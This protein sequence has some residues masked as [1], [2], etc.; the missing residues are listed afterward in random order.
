VPSIERFGIDYD[1]RLDRPPIGGAIT[2]AAFRFDPGQRR[3]EGG[4]WTDT[5]G[6]TPPPPRA[7]SRRSRTAVRATP[8]DSVELPPQ[9][10]LKAAPRGSIFAEGWMD[11]DDPA[12]RAAGF[13]QG[14]FRDQRA[15]RSVF[16]NI[17]EGKADPLDGIDLDRGW[18]LT[19][20][21]VEPPGTEEGSDA[22]VYDKGDLR[23]ELISA[24]RWLHRSLADAPVTTQP[25][26]R[27]MRMRRSEVPKVGESFD[28]DVV[29][30]AEER[31]WGEH[32]AEL[33]EDES[34]GRAGDTEVVFRLNGPKRSVDLGEGYLDEHLTQGRYRVTRVTGTGR[35]RFVTLE[36]VV[37]DE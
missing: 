25:L 24:A 11:S 36:E 22:R 10:P 17:T 21:R 37:G 18:N 23:N 28:A 16:R 9:P 30:W 31:Y 13:W 29:S 12:E 2:A 27:G 7:R 1:I 3:D 6:G 19:Y 20:L 4:R 8:S 5:G 26:Y 15:I 35:R 34:L 32:Y 14:A 33:P